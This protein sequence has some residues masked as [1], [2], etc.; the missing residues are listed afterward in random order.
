MIQVWNPKDNPLPWKW[1]KRQ[2]KFSARIKIGSWVEIDYRAGLPGWFQ[3][4]EISSDRD[5]IKV[6]G[7]EGEIVRHQMISYSN[8]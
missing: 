8:K 7:L 2:K 4:V 6:D 3:V 1:G 5:W